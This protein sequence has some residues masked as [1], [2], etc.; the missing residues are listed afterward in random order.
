MPEKKHINII[1]LGCSKNLVDS[2]KILGQLQHGNFKVS[3][4]AD[5]PADIVVINTCGFIHDAK[6]ESIDTILQYTEAKKQGLVSEVIVTGCL[7]QRYKDELKKEIPEADAWFGVDDPQDMFAYLKQKYSPDTQ[8]RFVT[9]P[10]HFAYL[11]IAEGCDRTCSF[12]AIPLI[13]GKFKS[14]TIDSLVTEAKQLAAKGVKELLLIA[15]DL[16]YYGYD[17]EKRAML[18]D[19][20]RALIPVEGIK[21]IRL[22][23]AYPKRFPSEVIDIMASEPKICRYLDIPLQHI[24]DKI[25]QSMRRNTTRTETLKL[26]KDFREKIPDV[27]LRTTL[28]VG[29]PGETKKDFEE[30]LE[31]VKS[32]RFDRLGVFTYSAEEGTRAY[33]LKDTVIQKEKERRVEAIMELQQT[34]SLELNQEKLGK[35]FRVLIDRAEGDYFSG[36]TEYDSPEVDNEVL[37]P[38]SSKIKTG[39]I[40]DVKIISAGEFELYGEVIF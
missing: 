30:L 11:K 1:T 31:F 15:Q 38:K 34:I 16:T 21:W 39:E 19:L 22:H 5:G 9:T 32:T 26:L 18:P 28:L 24:N 25:L 7:S 27:A 10:S 12:C 40:Y 4:D 17:L 33:T 14:R 23:Y 20:L 29:Y 35:V 13:R 8:E 37:I 3:H 36:R 6:T 2:E